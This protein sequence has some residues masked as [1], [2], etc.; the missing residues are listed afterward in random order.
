MYFYL[1]LEAKASEVLRNGEAAVV[2]ALMAGYLKPTDRLEIRSSKYRY[3]GLP[4]AN[5]W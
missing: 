5:A 1:R 3:S 2:I 4:G